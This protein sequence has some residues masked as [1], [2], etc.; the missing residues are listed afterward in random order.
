MKNSIKIPI[1]LSYSQICVF[2]PEMPSPYNDW[3]EIENR[4]GFSY[5][6]QSVSFATELDCGPVSILV[7]QVEIEPMLFPGAKCVIRVPFTIQSSRKVEIGSIQS[8]KILTFDVGSYALYFV[9]YGIN[10]NNFRLI[11]H[12]ACNAEVDILIESAN[13][14]RQEYYDLNAKPA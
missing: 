14:K 13:A 3:G 11:F 10:S 12:K 5:R 7:E 6:P 8:G 4:Q 2:D 9:D 1:I